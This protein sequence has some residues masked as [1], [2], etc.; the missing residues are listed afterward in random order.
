MNREAGWYGD[1]YFRTQERYWDGEAWTD[2]TRS[3]TGGT[4]P[5]AKP[6]G[7]I[8]S[9]ASPPSPA[10]PAAA[11][12]DG[13]LPGHRWRQRRP[14]RRQEDH[15]AAARTHQERRRCL[16]SRGGGTDSPGG[17]HRVRPAV[18]GAGTG[19]AGPA[20]RH[21]DRGRGPRGAGRRG[22]GRHLVRGGGRELGWKRG[23]RRRG[24]RHGVR[25]RCRRCGGE[26]APSWN[27]CRR[28]RREGVVSGR[29]RAPADP[30][31]S[32]SVRSQE[33]NRDDDV[34]RAGC[35][36]TGGDH[37]NCLCRTDRLCVSRPPPL[38][39][40]TGQDVGR[41]HG[42]GV[43]IAGFGPELGDQLLRAADRQP[44]HPGVTT[45]RRRCPL[46]LPRRLVVR[47][48]IRPAL[49]RQAPFERDD[50]DIERDELDR[51]VAVG[52]A[53]GRGPL[54]LVERSRQ[55]RRDSGRGRHP[56]ARPSTRP[57]RSCSPT[58]GMPL[59]SPLVP[60]AAQVATLARSIQAALDQT[61]ADRN[62]R[63]HAPS[64]GTVTP[65]PSRTSCRNG[66]RD[67][68]PEPRSA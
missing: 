61:G 16:R 38:R 9:A 18:D 58:T 67:S 24:W 68:P 7:S 53:R 6:A 42:G 37:P 47:R 39:A 13:P 46:H 1:P 21:R 31:G 66:N 62:P 19:R 29:V 45:Q 27:R 43:G 63:C 4:T 23:Q 32:R 51:F 14:G 59:S 33:R 44:D 22:R 60:P 30:L 54:R 40:G 52:R 5:A 8:G 56:T 2:R 11:P 35:P 55:G 20:A 26:D 57:S 64:A 15:Q 17:H 10:E 28:H 34:G 41:G 12:A 49:P 65:N 36:R 3:T 50:V 25:H 48:S